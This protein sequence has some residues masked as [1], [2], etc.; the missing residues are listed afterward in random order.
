MTVL[1][2]PTSSVPTGP[3]DP[4]DGMR[5]VSRP[6]IAK[7]P[8]ATLRDW[9]EAR[10]LP[11][12][13]KKSAVV[14]RL[15]GW[16][17]AHPPPSPQD[18]ASPPTIDVD[19]VLPVG[20]VVNFTQAGSYYVGMIMQLMSSHT[21]DYQMYKISAKT[22][23]V[24]SPEISAYLER[25][26][27]ELGDGADDDDNGTRGPSG[28]A[29]ND[30]VYKA[31]T[32]FKILRKETFLHGDHPVYT[33]VDPTGKTRLTV[34][35]SELMSATD[36]QTQHAAAQHA[37]VVTDQLQKDQAAHLSGNFLGQLGPHGVPGDHTRSGMQSVANFDRPVDF[38]ESS[39]PYMLDQLRDRAA[40]SDIIRASF[41]A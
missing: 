24:N 23:L 36:F 29:V 14:S 34:P 41:V 20:T 35:S 28:F 11:T 38:A 39:T 8:V 2:R 26:N 7:T 10:G 22:G 19:Q 32:A 27:F 37:E 18:S 12:S 33:I 30:V 15:Q 6:A 16:R 9:A 31:R 4:D 40:N 25:G 21:D 3:L 5:Q 13:G 17:D 1:P